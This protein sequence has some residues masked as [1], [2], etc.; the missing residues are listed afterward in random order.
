MECREDL[1]RAGLVKESIGLAIGYTATYLCVGLSLSALKSDLD[2]NI[3]DAIHYG[4]PYNVQQKMMVLDQTIVNLI[5]D[6][7]HPTVLSEEIM[8]QDDELQKVAGLGALRIRL[9]MDAC[10]LMLCCVFGDWITAETLI[11]DLEEFGD[12]RDPFLMRS[13]FRHCYVGLAAFALSRAEKDPKLRKKYLAIGKKM[14]KCFTK[15]MKCGSVNAFPIVQMLEAEQSPSKERYDKAIKATARLGLVH[16]EAYMCERAAEMFL[17]QGDDEWCKH[18]ISEAITLYGEWGATGKVNRLTNDYEDVLQGSTLQPS[19]NKSMQ[20]RSRYT[21]RELD[22]LRI[23]DWR[24]FHDLVDKDLDFSYRTSV[25]G[26]SGALS[27][28]GSFSSTI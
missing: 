9:G 22:S 5:D 26:G 3:A 4:C 1:L 6:V 14:L 27:S 12:E 18:Y 8:D 25:V 21:G 11:D 20:S 23:V 13:H 7:E 28:R 10:R 19:R 15:E 2:A 17:A 24:S 16:H